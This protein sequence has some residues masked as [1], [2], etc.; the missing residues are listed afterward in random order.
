M[1]C[2]WVEGDLFKLSL[3]PLLGFAKEDQ[4][5]FATRHKVTNTHFIRKIICFSF[6][7]LNKHTKESL[8]HWSV[9]RQ[10]K[11]TSMWTLSTYIY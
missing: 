3:C 5:I 6:R 1:D 9:Y 7:I 10:A 8:E 2:I 11:L 4:R